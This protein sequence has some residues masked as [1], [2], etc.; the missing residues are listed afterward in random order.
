MEKKTPLTKQMANHFNLVLKL[1][2]EESRP[3]RKRGVRTCPSPHYPTDPL[4][5][6]KTRFLPS[7]RRILVLLCMWVKHME[8]PR[9]GRELQTHS[10]DHEGLRDHC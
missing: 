4:H 9:L 5:S 7:R 1:R 6:R 8:T 2:D 10:G 3:L